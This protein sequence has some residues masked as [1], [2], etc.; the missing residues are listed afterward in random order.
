[1]RLNYQTIWPRLDHFFTPNLG[2]GDSE[3]S[4]LLSR[5]KVGALS[6]LGVSFLHWS[7]FKMIL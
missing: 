5:R 6:T 2:V 7:C 3:A 4:C 1:M